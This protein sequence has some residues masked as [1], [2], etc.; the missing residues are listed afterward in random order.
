VAGSSGVFVTAGVRKNLYSRVQITDRKSA[1]FS[2]TFT[3]FTVSPK[4]NNFKFYFFPTR[5]ENATQV[6]MKPKS[7]VW[8]NLW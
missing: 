6:R 7:S 4:E 8:A 3:K 5:A 1:V 2:I